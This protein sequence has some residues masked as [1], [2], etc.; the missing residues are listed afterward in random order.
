[1]IRYIKLKIE[2]LETEEGGQ[3][4]LVHPTAKP[5]PKALLAKAKSHPACGPAMEPEAPWIEDGAVNARMEQIRE[6]MG[7]LENALH[8]ILIHLTPNWAIRGKFDASI[9]NG[10]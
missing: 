4:M 7:N 9:P 2:S 10:V 8:Q 1:M 6:R 3:Q 5:A